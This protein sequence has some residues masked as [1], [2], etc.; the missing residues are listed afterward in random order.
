MKKM[1]FMISLLSLSLV[2]CGGQ[3]GAKPT[4]KNITAVNK[5]TTVN[6]TKADFLEKV[7]DYEKDSENWNY[8]GEK[9][10]IIDFYAD[11]CGPCK[12]VAPILE[13]L[14]DE[15][16]DDIIIY[17]VNVDN[18]QELAGLFG[19]KNIPTFL[20]IPMEGTPSLMSGMMNKAKFE[21]IIKDV[22]L[23]QES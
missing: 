3:T 14:A 11:W 4:D 9:P 12:K 7:V 5:I 21:N 19:I 8:L 1:L 23:V 10:A 15:Y 17:K 13:E 18:E 2:S 22:L 6:M 20:F 16:G